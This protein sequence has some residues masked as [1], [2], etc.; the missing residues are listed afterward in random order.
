VDSGRHKMNKSGGGVYLSIGTL[1]GNMK[2]A[3]LPENL[4]ERCVFRGWEVEGSV[5]R[6]LST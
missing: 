4:K 2:G 3:L 1:L 5:D 6:C